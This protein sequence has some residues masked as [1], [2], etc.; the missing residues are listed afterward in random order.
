MKK[1]PFKTARRENEEMALQITSMADIFTIL[2]VFLLKSYTT[3][4]M[5]I[6]P[7][8]GVKLPS[9]IVGES[10]IEALKVEISDGSVEV[11]GKPVATLDHYIFAKEISSR[12][13]PLTP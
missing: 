9:A 12:T 4:A 13:A 3:G 2:L 10:N 7:S 11:E 8:S 1:S 6:S 5:S